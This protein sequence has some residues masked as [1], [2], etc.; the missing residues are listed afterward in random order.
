[1]RRKGSRY[2]NTAAFSAEKGFSGFRERRLTHPPGLVEHTVAD[3]DRLDHVANQ[4]Y[5]N[6]RRWW[7]VL[8]ANAD[9]LYCFELLDEEMYGDVITVPASREQEK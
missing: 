9:F 8:D 4:Y 7:R 5:R 3:T 2:E 6:D 1:M